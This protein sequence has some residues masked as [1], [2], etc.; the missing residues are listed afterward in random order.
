MWL[1]ICRYPLSNEGV[2]VVMAPINADNS[3]DLEKVLERERDAIN[4]AFGVDPEML[5][6]HL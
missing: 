2:R 5:Y 6:K 1:G 4:K 3:N